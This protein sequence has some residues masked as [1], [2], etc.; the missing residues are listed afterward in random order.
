MDILKIILYY[1]ILLACIFF[2]FLCLIAGKYEF[3]IA[4]LGITIPYATIFMNQDFELK[5]IKVNTICK[6]NIELYTQLSQIV[7]KLITDL[8]C[9]EHNYNSYNFYKES[10]KFKEEQKKNGKNYYNVPPEEETDKELHLCTQQW[11]DKFK[12]D[13]NLLYELYEANGISFS[14]SV[15]KQ[16]RNV[17]D[18]KC[19]SN[20]SVRWQNCNLSN[21]KN[22][23]LICFY[24][25]YNFCDVIKLK[26]ELNKFMKVIKKDLGAC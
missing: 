7:N 5:K 2:V 17:V 16:Y 12:E 1:I 23:A 9:L 6:N 14:Y 8:S 26:K 18:K 10:R 13:I 3:A 22:S 4:I 15:D 24:A 11:I 25:S 21:D 19:I 20:I